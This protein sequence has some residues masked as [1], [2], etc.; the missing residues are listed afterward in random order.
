[1]VTVALILNVDYL[2]RSVHDLTN[3]L[4]LRKVYINLDEA[5]D[6]DIKRLARLIVH[7]TST[8]LARMLFDRVIKT[9]YL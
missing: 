2:D 5:G 8:H 3:S 7:D 4:V 1:M 6:C 9:N